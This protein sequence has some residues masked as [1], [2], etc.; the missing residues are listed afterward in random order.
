[1]KTVLGTLAAV[2]VAAA[3]G[4][5][6]LLIFVDDVPLLV[7]AIALGLLLQGG[8]TLAYLAGALAQFEPHARQVFL[9]GHTLALLVGLLGAVST[10]AYNINP[11]NGDNEYGPM[12]VALLILTLAVI[13][14]WSEA[15]LEKRARTA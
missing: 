13:A 12:T 10:V 8:Y 1:M 15:L 5:A 14:V 3:A 6:G 7:L 4:L 9:I 11:P 2:N